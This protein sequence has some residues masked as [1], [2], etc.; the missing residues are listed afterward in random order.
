MG[1]DWA[2]WDCLP[3]SL[4][5]P[6]ERIVSASREMSSSNWVSC[7]PSVSIREVKRPWVVLRR[8]VGYIGGE[9]MVPHLTRWCSNHLHQPF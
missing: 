5:Y 7:T 8:L 3:D 1:V 4:A 2:V 9:W 6:S